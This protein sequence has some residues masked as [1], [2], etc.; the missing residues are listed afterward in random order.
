MSEITICTQDAAAQAICLKKGSIQLLMESGSLHF[1]LY[2]YIAT[3]YAVK[4]GRM[5]M[6][7]CDRLSAVTLLADIDDGYGGLAEQITQF[8]REESRG[9]TMVRY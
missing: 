6:E 4:F 8:I 5:L 3:N 2:M 1:L 7:D 9:I